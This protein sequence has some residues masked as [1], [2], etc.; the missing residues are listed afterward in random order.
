MTTDNEKRRL[1]RELDTVEKA[2]DLLVDAC[3]GERPAW[4]YSSHILTIRRVTQFLERRQLA[5]LL[6]LAKS[7]LATANVLRTGRQLGYSEQAIRKAS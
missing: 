6:R 2:W 5:I 7:E 3:K 1:L 4:V